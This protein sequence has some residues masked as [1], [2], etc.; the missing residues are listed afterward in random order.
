MPEECSKPARTVTHPRCCRGQRT[1]PPQ[2][3]GSTVTDVHLIFRTL[4]LFWS[5]RRRPALG[6][7]DVGRMTLRVLPT[8]LDILGHM[9]NG[10][11]LSLMDLGRMDLMIRE[12]F[13]AKLRAHK[14][15]PVMVSET[16]TFRRSLNPWE[17]FVLETRVIGV[18]DKAVYVEQRFV[19]D[20]EIA[21]QAMTR[22]RF[23]QAGAGTVSIERLSELA[24]T[25][26][27]EFA[28]PE[29]VTAW[30]A[31]V[32]LPPRKQPTPSVWDD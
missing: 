9:N 24:G 10:V 13:W 16:I 19:I 15:Y 30:A 3:S 22:A 12:G 27:S 11:Y 8:D 26:L 20:G 28:L 32:T 29:W 23:L 18:D 25:D 6:M 4:I 7:R 17:K 31:A 14:M 2:P 21:A 1:A 5:A